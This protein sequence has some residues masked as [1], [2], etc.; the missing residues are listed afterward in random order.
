MTA[1]S[2]N[3]VLYKATGGAFHCF[4][5]QLNESSGFVCLVGPALLD[6][7][8]VSRDP[9]MQSSVW[10]EDPC[11]VECCLALRYQGVVSACAIHW[12]VP[13]LS[14]SLQVNRWVGDFQG[15]GIL[16][17]PAPAISGHEAFFSGGE[18]CISGVYL[19]APYSKNF[20][21]ALFE[22]P[23]PTPRRVFSGVG[24]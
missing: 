23:P 13:L 1:K 10:I 22:T 21:R 14:A 8:A 15:E 24:P 3:K 16:C 12:H 7:D 18:G 11:S 19:E 2:N 6:F 4:Q 9:L 20:I 5:T 17:T